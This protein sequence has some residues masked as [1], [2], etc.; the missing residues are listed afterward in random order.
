MSAIKKFFEEERARKNRIRE[1]KMKQCIPKEEVY[2]VDQEKLDEA[3]QTLKNWKIYYEQDLF[4][5]YTGLDQEE[6]EYIMKKKDDF[7]LEVRELLWGPT[8]LYDSKHFIKLKCVDLSDRMYQDAKMQEQLEFE[9]K[10]QEKLAQCKI[11]VRPT[12]YFDES[13]NSLQQKLKNQEEQL[14][15]LMK[16]PTK[17]YVP[18]S[19]RKQVMLS[20]PAVQDMAKKIETT[21]NEIAVCEKYVVDSNNGWRDLKQLEF[22]EDIIKEMFEM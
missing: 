4:D 12:N 20:D 19:M 5:Y 1:A 11:P 17:R 16:A 13:L 22:R 6:Y 15:T 10:V 2:I 8:P 18:P 7:P 9:T 14:E 21:K 3:Y